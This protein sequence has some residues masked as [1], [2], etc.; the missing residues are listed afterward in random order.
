MSPQIVISVQHV[1]KSYGA[2][3]AVDEL[4]F[5]VKAGECCGFL[6]PNGAGKTTMMKILYAKAM[7]DRDAATEISVFGYDPRKQELQIKS[8]SGV[9]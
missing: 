5:D 7:P 3:K 4:A 2:L 6:G 9:A 8:L 1:N